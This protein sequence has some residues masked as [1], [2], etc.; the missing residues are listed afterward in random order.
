MPGLTLEKLWRKVEFDPNDEQRKAIRHVSG[1][2]YLTAGPGSGKT[3]VL[4]WRTLNLI[5]FHD[6]RPER[7]FLGTFT[8]K[9]AHQ[10]REGLRGLLALATD[11]TGIP[12]DISQMAVGTVHQI[13]HQLLLRRELVD[14]VRRPSVPRLL[15]EFSQYRFFI[16]RRRLERLLEAGDFGRD[17]RKTITTYLGGRPSVSRHETVQALISFFNRCSEESIDPGTALK[18]TR[19]ATLQA[20][21]KAYAEYL[22]TLS[23]DTDRQFTDLS[24]L[25]QHAYRRISASD[26]GMTL[27]DH[28]IVDEYQDTNPIQEKIYFR[29]A[30]G[31]NNICVVGDDDQALYR[32]RGGTVD[33]FLAFSQRC[34]EYLK[35]KA[36]VIPLV[37][38]YRSRSGIVDFYNGFMQQINWVHRGTPF[39]VKKV[40]K[41]HKRDK[42]SVV[43]LPG[44]T[45]PA[46]AATEVAKFVRQLVDQKR[47][48]D[49]NEIAFLFPS[50]KSPHVERLREALE[51]RDLNVYAPRASTFIDVEEALQIF[52]LY[53]LIFGRPD[54]YHPGFNQWMELAAD[55]AKALVREDRALAR[56]VKDKQDEIAEFVDAETK[57]RKALTRAGLE[58][59]S[60]F[61]GK[62]K[63]AV[64]KASVPERIKR[65]LGGRSLTAYIEHQRRRRPDRPI[66]VRYVLNRAC[67][68][69]WGVL[70]LFY[71]LTAFEALKSA[72]DLAEDGEDEGPICN[73]SLISDYLA[74]Y[75]EE[76]SPVIGA[77]FLRDERFIQSFFSSYLYSIYRLGQ[78]EYEDKQDPFPKGRI[79]FLTIHQSKGLEFRVVVLGNLR[80]DFGGP[81][82]LDEIAA[83]LVG[84][85]SE[86][87][88]LASTFDVMRMFYVALSR[89]A[90]LL[91]LCPYRGRGQ[92]VNAEFETPMEKHASSLAELDLSVV[93]PK[94][95]FGQGEVPRP[96]SFTGDYI[97]YSICPRRYMLYRR[98]NFAPSRTQTTIFGNLV[99]QTIEDLHLWLI[100]QR[101]GTRTQE[102]RT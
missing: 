28:V 55:T 60:P 41:A 73:L 40:I 88:E 89:A 70:D 81:R 61:D 92:R 17:P 25:Q 91:V 24:L 52:G 79:P 37:T 102:A 3:R 34:V 80:K 77:Q 45:D 94:E 51:K 97:S 93:N 42:R 95:H 29:L 53:L 19:D 16:G 86:P 65:F 64:L 44:N 20:L 36:T 4:L 90:H 15:D 48:N 75:Q 5:V 67:S 71:H 72:F 9:G 57:L 66:T 10:L 11:E 26:R 85:R 46:S 8:E 63:A 7:I 49:P 39:R 33:N 6:V 32:F 62:A 18:R 22:K 47:V 30:K 82:K 1:P 50:L 98:Y 2:L 12:F 23:E 68:L 87:L 54:H 101:N 59:D 56:F 21:L 31:T 43:A 69:D 58:D 96:Y 27:F 100:A 76:T 83:E 84:R 99:H 38:N 74:R 35:T 13:C 14:G 78:G